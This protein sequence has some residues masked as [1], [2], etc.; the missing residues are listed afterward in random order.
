MLYIVYR[1]LYKLTTDI[2]DEQACLMEPMGVAHNVLDRIGIEKK[3]ILI[4]GCGTVGLLTVAC[5]QAM[6]AK[7]GLRTC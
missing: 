7:R 6:G 2:S 5:A 3:S 1:Y 4:I